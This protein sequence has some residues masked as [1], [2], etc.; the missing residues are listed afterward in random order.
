MKQYK[1]I[2]REKC[3]QIVKACNECKEALEQ[4]ELTPRC[5]N[6]M[7]L[8]RCKLAKEILEELEK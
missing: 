2:M 6:C 1:K 7:S 5:E 8:S 3:S 4:V